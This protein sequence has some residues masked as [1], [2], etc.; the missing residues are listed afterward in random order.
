MV[1]LQKKKTTVM[2]DGHV[3]LNLQWEVEVRTA[4]LV[5]CHKTE[6]SQWYQKWSCVAH[7]CL[8]RLFRATDGSWL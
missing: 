6:I 7:I 1:L 4:D 8:L 2:E 3:L 5:V